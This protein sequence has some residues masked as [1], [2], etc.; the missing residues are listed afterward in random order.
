MVKPS[1]YSGRLVTI[2]MGERTMIFREVQNEINYLVT[3]IL[4]VPGRR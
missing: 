2:T 3:L 4:G 1:V